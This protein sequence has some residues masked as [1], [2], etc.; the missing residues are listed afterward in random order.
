MHTP[1]YMFMHVY[2]YMSVSIITCM[3]VRKCIR[4]YVSMYLAQGLPPPQL[5]LVTRMTT[6]SSL[7]YTSPSWWGFTDASDRSRLDRQLASLR[8]AG[9]LPPDFP[10]FDELAR[11][12]DAGLFQSI[13]SNPDHVLRHYFTDKRPTGHNLRPR[14]HS[15]ALPSKDPRNFVSWTL[16]GA[17]LI[18]D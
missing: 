2:M 8:R 6:L 12:A 1:M 10:S 7:M 14:A 3:Y 16:Y 5:H 18:R 17:V 9:F 11:N 4:M 13:C 15:F